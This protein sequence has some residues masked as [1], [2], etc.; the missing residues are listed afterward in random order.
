MKNCT[1]IFFTL[2]LIVSDG[3]AAWQDT[4]A[5]HF[6]I[7]ET[8]DELQDWRGGDYTRGRNL[9]PDN[10]PEN[11]DGS[12]SIWDSFDYWPTEPPVNDWIA[13]HGSSNTWRGTGK[14]LIMDMDQNIDA[15]KGPA[16][17]GCY[18]GNYTYGGV[19]PFSSSGTVESGY[20]DVYIFAMI[21]FHS[22]GFP[23]LADG[24]TNKYYSYY[25]WHVLA[26]GMTSAGVCVEGRDDCTY[27]ASNAHTMLYIGDATN[28]GQQYKLEYYNDAL[29]P[30]FPAEFQMWKPLNT[31]GIL[32]GYISD[33][34]WFGLEVHVHMGTP[35][36]YDGYQEQWI[37]DEDGSVQY[38]G[39][40]QN[41][42]MMTAGRDWGFN[43]FFQGGNISFQTDVES[44]GLDPSYYFDDF[45]MD[46]QRIGP[47]YFALLNN[48]EPPPPP[49]EDTTAPA[50]PGNL[51]VR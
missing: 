43:Y 13:D 22:N 39:K 41:M 18:F 38:V 24:V 31:I 42:I 15:N 34:K 8:F 30:D 5:Q 40:S 6:D 37:Y 46:A 49:D 47:T 25:K 17:L 16:R 51:I 35:G 9:D 36:Q 32:D 11:L 2:F 3:Y 14:S 27:G 28:L 29:W 50:S 45:I 7:V 33:E 44:Q 19:N 21:K 20:R 12:P 26:T 48:N 23:E 4:L 1:I 10:M